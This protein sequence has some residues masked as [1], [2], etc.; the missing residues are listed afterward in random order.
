L[1]EPVSPHTITTWWRSTAE[2]ISSRLA[3]MGSAG[4][5]AIRF[6]AAIQYQ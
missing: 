3:L 6:T 1:P 5:N 2:R 4:S